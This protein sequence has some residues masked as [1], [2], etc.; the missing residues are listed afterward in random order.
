MQENTI[1]QLL[2]DLLI[3]Q[4]YTYHTDR[5]IAPGSDNELRTSY[6]E[7]ILS[8]ILKE[9]LKKINPDLDQ[10]ILD[11]AYRKILNLEW[12]DL[13]SK[14][15]IFHDL[16]RN[17]CTIERFKN[18]ET[19]WEY[20]RYFDLEN[21]ENNDFRVVNQFKVSENWENKRFDVVI[22]INWIPVVICELKNPLDPDADMFHAF[23]QIQNYQTAIPSIFNYNWI[24]MI[25]DWLDARV[26]SFTAPFSRYLTRHAPKSPEGD[27]TNQM[28][29]L[30]G[31]LNTTHW[32][33]NTA[34]PA[35]YPQLLEKAREMRDKP[36]EAERAL[37]ES[38]RNNQLWVKFRQQHII[39]NFI[40]DFC[41]LSHKLVVEVD[42][43]IHNNQKEA[44][45]E[46]TEILESYGYKVIR[47]T[48]DEV[49]NNLDSVL[50]KIKSELNS[51]LGARSFERDASNSPLGARG[52][53]SCGATSP[54][55]GSG[56]LLG[57]SIGLSEIEITSKYLFDKKTLLNV[58]ANYT[59][60]EKEEKKDKKTWQITQEKIKKV[61]A[62]HQYYAVEKAIASTIK[63]T[64]SNHKIWVVWHTQWSGKSLSMVFYVWQLIK[65]PEMKNPTILVITDRN[66]L[67]DQ[68][69]G[70]FANSRG[71]LRQTPQQASDR[72]DLKKLL[73][74]SGWWI[75]FSTIQKFYPDEWSTYETLSERENII[76]IADEAHRS[77]YGFKAKV[78]ENKDWSWAEIR[79]WNAKYL[80]DALPNASFI[81]FTGTPIEKT[82]KST[83]WVFG[84]EIDVYDIKQAVED[85]ATVPINYESRL[86]KIWVEQKVLDKIENEINE[87]DW[88]TDEQKES[89]KSRIAQ[90]DTLVW[91]PERLK[92]LAK[93]LVEHFETR[94]WLF[95]WKAMFVWMTRWILVRFYDEL[96]KLR[97]NW[98][99]LWLVKVVMTSSTDDP[100]EFQPH[101]TTSAERK[102]L[103][104]DFKDPKS[105]FKLA[106]VC[107]M[108]LTWFDVPCLHTMYFDKKLQ[109]AALMQAIARVNRVYKDKPGWLIVDYIWIAQDL[110][111]AMAV[112]TASGW[113]GNAYVDKETA[114]SEMF[115]RYEAVKDI[116]H[117]CNWEEYFT[118]NTKEKLSIIIQTVD[119]VLSSDDIRNSFL[120]QVTAVSRLFALV[121]PSMKAVTIRDDL[122]FFQAIKSRI[123]KI[124]QDRSR[125]YDLETTI[126]QEIDSAFSTQWVVDIFSAAWLEKPSISLLS[127][128]FLLEVKNMKQK[129]V[130]LELLK[131]ILNDELKVRM[132]TNIAQSRIFSDMMKDLLN[133]YTSN[134]LDTTQVIQELCEI[135][136][137]LHVEDNTAEELWLT[138]EEYAFYT[139]LSQ[140]ESTKFL[141]DEKMKELIHAI[142][143]KVRKNATWLRLQKSNIQAQL[144]LEVKKLLMKYGYPPDLARME[145]DKVLEQS[146]LLAEDMAVNSIS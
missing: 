109:W 122:A 64:H 141:E 5:D 104:L 86:I 115:S 29:L 32:S 33:M 76:V 60:F 17:G 124:T 80:R 26:S 144:R 137:N 41:C 94:Q 96:I 105:N 99:T 75:V 135:A 127:D 6:E 55:R 13:V 84:D 92:T 130:A 73:K 68:L 8:P 20:V 62:Y 97:P 134:Q 126:Q 138:P 4:W 28:E 36:T 16:L 89:I 90:L 77:Q 70:T 34:N 140:N 15:E 50:E 46:R 38:L 10:W 143:E 81:W 131:R 40:T 54:F 30:E 142:V 101:H 95:E 74:V 117:W 123:L 9:R 71:L 116:L 11:E 118:W 14:N 7:V 37:R 2:I 83:R 48:N 146:E 114:I 139:V 3:E 31:D 93:D 49:L 42:G 111:N 107:D 106:L 91:N 43:W 47:F 27:L 120:K 102:E 56:G 58:L 1:E 57:G 65:H 113:K 45:Q 19:R 59:V 61:A 132:K 25:S 69:F 66:D 119:F 100:K 82:D 52:F 63:A 129:N 112:Y 98:K 24:C 53:E 145:A 85:W 136:H 35:I 108:W 51:P 22:F 23:T 21:I 79:Y 39:D 18:G 88:A 133:R 121:M 103:A 12:S 78:V 72:E 125:N 110:R 87:F 44:D 128:K 67:D